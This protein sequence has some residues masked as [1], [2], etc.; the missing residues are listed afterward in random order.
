M[1]VDEIYKFIEE[2]PSTARVLVNTSQLM[3]YGD[4]WQEIPLS[5]IKVEYCHED[6]PTPIKNEKA[7]EES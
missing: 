1:T 3:S 2:C 6:M 7:D 4:K 5:A